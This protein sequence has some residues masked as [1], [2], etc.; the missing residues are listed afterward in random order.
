MK[1][2]AYTVKLNGDVK[3]KWQDLISG[4]MKDYDLSTIGD[5]YPILIDIITSNSNLTSPDL[6]DYIRAIRTNLDGVMKNV[7]AI[8]GIYKSTVENNEQ[9]LNEARA[10]LVS[11]LEKEAQANRELTQELEKTTNELKEA[12]ELIA[13]LQAEIEQLKTDKKTQK[14]ILD[15]LSELKAKE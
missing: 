7:L 4:I 6:S 5:V 11:Q 15:L 3:E 2:E 13:D 14:E 1:N 12:K 9:A 10:N 8:D